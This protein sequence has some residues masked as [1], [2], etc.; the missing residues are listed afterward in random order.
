MDACF[1][2]PEFT[3]VPLNQETIK[4]RKNLRYL[5]YGEFYIIFCKL[6]MLGM[7]SAIF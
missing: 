3:Q 4:H 6:M 1:P 2:N 7:L 5:M